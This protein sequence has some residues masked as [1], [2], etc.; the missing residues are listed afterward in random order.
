M[1]SAARSA[2]TTGHHVASLRRCLPVLSLFALACSGGE[3][4]GRVALATT[5]DTAQGV[6]HVRNAGEPPVWRLDSVVTIDSAGP[7]PLG[8]VTGVVGDWKGGIYVAD[9]LAHRVYRYDETGAWLGALGGE[10]SGPGE[11]RSLQG[12]AWVGGRLASL[13]AGNARITLLAADGAAEPQSV[14]WQP[15]T[16]DVT[17]E[18]TR[19]GEAYAPVVIG[20]PAR[21]GRVTSGFVRLIGAGVPD[22]IADYRGEV[23]GSAITCV[24]PDRISAF[25]VP[26]A[27]QPYAARAPELRTVV[28]NTG[29]Y[30]LAL[31]DRGGDTLRVIERALSPVPVNEAEWADASARWHRF[32]EQNRDARCDADDITRPAA[33]PAFR[34]TFW[35]DHGRLWVEAVTPTG[36]RYDLFDT[37]GVLVGE[38]PAPPRDRSVSPTVRA[39]RLFWVSSDSLDVQSVKAARIVET[40]PAP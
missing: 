40:L 37:T 26:Y 15:I 24:A 8:R 4:S 27:V 10:G 33:K 3:G 22:T 12:L 29:Q 13:D 25:A 34:S 18:Q 21:D 28:G 5:V 11:F 39:G 20:E 32:R 36:F 38:L 19:P 31:L 7:A 6:V 9:A 14:R 35:D 17:L 30:R 23:A 2:N 1:T 16:G